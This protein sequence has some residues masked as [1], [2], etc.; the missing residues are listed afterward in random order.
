MLVAAP[1]AR[2]GIVREAEGGEQ[3]H[4]SRQQQYACSSTC[5]ETGQYKQQQPVTAICL[6]QQLQAGRGRVSLVFPPP[7]HP[8]HPPTYHPLHPHPACILPTPNAELRSWSSSMTVEQL[9]EKVEALTGTRDTQVSRG[10]AGGGRGGC[11]VTLHSLQQDVAGG[12]LTA[13]RNT[14]Q[15][16][17][18]GRHV[19]C[20]P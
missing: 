7:T 6:Q 10:G 12:S 18:R 4:A 8:P 5:I 9:R 15:V 19:V 2:Q 14:W 20:S 17:V 1:A 3:Q 11:P 16:R 13:T